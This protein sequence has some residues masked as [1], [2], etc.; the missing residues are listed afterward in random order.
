MISVT[1]PLDYEQIPNG[2]IHLKVMAKDGGNPALNNTVPVTVE[3]IVSI[4]PHNTHTTHTLSQMWQASVV[5]VAIICDI[6]H[7]SFQK[8]E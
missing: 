6:S 5:L 2:M 3:V 4:I 1:R 8:H 7:I